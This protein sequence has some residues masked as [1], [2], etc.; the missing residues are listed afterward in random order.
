MDPNVALQELREAL[1]VLADGTTDVIDQDQAAY[2]V[3]ESA[4]ALDEWLTAGGY[5]P[6]AWRD[7]RR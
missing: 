7:N 6:A 1:A 4:K 3:A 5:L 2:D